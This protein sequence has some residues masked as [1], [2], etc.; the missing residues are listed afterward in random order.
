MMANPQERYIKSLETKITITGKEVYMSAIPKK[1]EAD[2][3]SDVQIVATDGTR[4][5]V[6]AFE[7]F[8]NAESWWAIAS[9][10]GRVNGSLFFTPGKKILIP[11]KK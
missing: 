5:D 9:A 10:N 2:N 7:R 4:M 8:G 1:I 6:L 11:S 3:T